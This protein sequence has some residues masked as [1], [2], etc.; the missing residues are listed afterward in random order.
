MRPILLVVDPPDPEALSTR[1]LILESQKYNVLTAFT[2]PEAK[3][4]AQR[5]PINAVVL[6]ERVQD[7]D[8][9][10]L[11]AELKRVRPEIPIWMVAPQPLITVPNVDR[12]L[13]SFDPL[14]LVTLAERTFGNYIVKDEAD[15][16]LNPPPSK[17]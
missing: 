4:I 12:V 7:G 5:V 8:S 9:A 17:K 2:G 6:H 15:R 1:K 16:E 13:S 11:A 14:A 3:E 10:G